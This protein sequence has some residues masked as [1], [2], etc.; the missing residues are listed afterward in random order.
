MLASPS[1]AIDLP[2]KILVAEDSEGKVSISYNSSIYLQ[3]RHL[4]P[5]NLV[6]NIAVVD[7]LVRNAAQ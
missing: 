3:H 5:E 4:L 6:A 1:I 7:G 2:L